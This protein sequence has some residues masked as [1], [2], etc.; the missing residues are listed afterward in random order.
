MPQW[1]A[2]SFSD[3]TVKKAYLELR[4]RKSNYKLVLIK[5]RLNALS[6]HLISYGC[7]ISTWKKT[8]INSQSYLHQDWKCKLKA[9]Y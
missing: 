2:F 3:N 5:D 7:A 8:D 4:F 6:D 1:S 9:I